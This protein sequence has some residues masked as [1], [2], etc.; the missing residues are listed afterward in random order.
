MK[1]K[2]PDHDLTKQL[3]A[4]FDFFNK[5]LWDGRL[6]PA[7]LTLQRKANSAGYHHENAFVDRAHGDSAAS[8]IAM[9]PDHFDKSD[10]VILS[11]LVHEMA[12]HWQQYFGKPGRGAYHNQ[13]W[14]NEMLRVGLLA[15]NVKNPQIATGDKISHTIKANGLFEGYCKIFLATGYTLQWRSRK[16]TQLPPADGEEAEPTDGDEAEREEEAAKQ[17]NKTKYTCPVCQTNL[18]GKPKL[19]VICGACAESFEEQ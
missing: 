3:Q 15:Y 17:K 6:P 10:D 14:A 5:N 8:E 16:Y 19:D 18:W 2:L 13:Q 12:H 11:V 7:V 9:N 1:S 4:A